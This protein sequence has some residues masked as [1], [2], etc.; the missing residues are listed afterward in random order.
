LAEVTGPGLFACAVIVA[1]A[2]WIWAAT[3]PTT[4]VKLAV[5]PFANLTGNMDRE[6]LADGLTEEAT[7]TL[8]QI[9]P[10]QLSVVGRQS[11]MA[12]KRSSKSLVAIGNELGVNYVVE[13][14]IQDSST[15]TLRM[16]DAG[17]TGQAPCMLPRLTAVLKMTS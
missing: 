1:F 13:S 2:V 7:V 4:P 11:V 15:P 8:A 12:Y 6:Y 16:K 17:L 10:Q 9:A 5:L 3:R 14:S